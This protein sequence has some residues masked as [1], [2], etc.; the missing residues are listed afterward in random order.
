MKFTCIQNNLRKAISSVEKI[1]TKQTSLPI[2]KNILLEA[3]DGRIVI[4]ATNLEIG[5]ISEIGAKIEREGKIAVPTRV[6]SEF[7]NSLPGS[8]KIIIELENNSLKVKSGSFEAKINCLG[9]ESFPIIP[10]RKDDYHL[11]VNKDIFNSV[12]N[13]V[14]S[15]ASVNDM[16]IEFNGVNLKVSGNKL[17]FAST[18]SF[19]LAEYILTVDGE[20]IMKNKDL[21][22][23]IDNN[24]FIIPVE[25]VREI[26]KS[27]NIGG[28]DNYI[29]IA[30]ENNQIFFKIGD[31]RIISR[32]INGNFPDY[33]QIIPTNFNTEIVLNRNDL[34]KAVKSVSVFVGSDKEITLNIKNEDDLIEIKSNGSELGENKV[35]VYAN[36]S[37][38]KY[39]IIV[40]Y[41][42]LLDGLNSFNS[43]EI[44]VSL[45]SGFSPIVIRNILDNKDAEEFLYLIMPIKK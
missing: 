40:N 12:I 45:E 39:K 15:A 18:N 23:S 11:K 44:T 27:I 9:S 24:Q 2:L 36:I 21:Y 16:R 4:S 13:R 37:G 34:L 6:F 7:I 22:Q 35:E 1:T 42:Y 41:Q 19:R 3:R 32:L 20:R 33:K 29:E 38:E 14:A 25:T 26:S 10:Q 31:I 30:L 28:D 8:E 17:C 43:D 5:I